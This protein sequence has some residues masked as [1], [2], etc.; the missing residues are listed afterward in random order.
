MGQ[1]IAESENPLAVA[2]KFAK[3][4]STNYTTRG[5]SERGLSRTGK[6]CRKA[7]SSGRATE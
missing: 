1:T 2:K 3:L 7:I 4:G 5:K 6:K